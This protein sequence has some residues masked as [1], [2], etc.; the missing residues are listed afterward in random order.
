MILREVQIPRLL[1]MLN[2]LKK[3]LAPYRLVICGWSNKQKIGD[4]TTVYN[5]NREISVYVHR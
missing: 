2:M 3:D 4:Y 1:Y 5:S